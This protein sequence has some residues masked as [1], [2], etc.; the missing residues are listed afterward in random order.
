MKISPKAKSLFWIAL[1]TSVLVLSWV[2]LS[3]LYPETNTLRYLP[4]RIFRLVKI[5]MGNDP[6]LPNVEQANMPLALIIVKVLITIILLRALLKIVEKVFHEQYTHMRIACKKRHLIV[7]GIGNKGSRILKD[8]Q[9]QTGRSAVAIEQKSDHANLPAL[10]RDGHAVVA[11]NAT[12]EEVLQAAG[13]LKAHTVICFGDDEQTGI[14]AASKLTELYARQ[15]PGHVLRCFVHLKNPRL[16]EV[17]QQHGHT[18]VYSGVDVR[19][20]NLH[21]VIARNFFH[22]LPYLLTDALQHPQVQIRFLLLGFDAAAQALLLQ[23]LRVFHLLPGQGSTWHVFAQGIASKAATF[24]DRYPHIARITPLQFAEDTGCYGQWMQQYTRHESANVQTIVICA[25][26]DDRTNLLAA[27]EILRASDQQNWPIF[28]LNAGGKAMAG[29]LSGH[30]SARLHFFGDYDDFCKYELIT[31]MRQDDLAQAIH[32][33]YLQQVSEAASES[34]AYQTAWTDLSENAKDANRA[35]A[36]HI[37]YKLLLT[38]KQNALQSPGSL[39]FTP[40]EIEQLSITEHAR[41]AAHR[42]L[43]GWQYGA[44]R[45]DVR[46]LHPSLID[47]EQLSDSERQKDRHTVLRLPQILQAVYG[48]R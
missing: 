35:Q 33:D 28:V 3:Q 20:F 36:D 6:A 39:R 30:A 10:R 41:W 31:G 5:L 43:N 25:S 38:H 44:T 7:V 29:L 24:H 40:A 11:G 27:T 9:V 45:D 17:F 46:K 1:V 12:D 48:K 14:Q 8:Y 37:V 21:K 18:R 26:D 23:A 47:W 15:K 16:V 22:R 42:Y 32:N 4:D 19:F 13:A 34:A 2:G